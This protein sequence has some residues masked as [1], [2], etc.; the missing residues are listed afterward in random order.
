MIVT[1]P[2]WP[3]AQNLQ[4]CLCYSSYSWPQNVCKLRRFAGFKLPELPSAWPDLDGVQHPFAPGICEVS[5]HP[6]HP[7]DVLSYMLRLGELRPLALKDVAFAP[8]RRAVRG[9][10]RAA[11]P[12]VELV[13]E[14]HGSQ[15]PVREAAS[16]SSHVHV[17]GSRQYRTRTMRELPNAEASGMSPVVSVLQRRVGFAPFPAAFFSGGPSSII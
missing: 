10:D 15:P 13:D 5:I 2:G 3:T 6:C 17:S 16:H 7:A 12:A 11:D 4:K 8:R 1:C 9:G 14:G